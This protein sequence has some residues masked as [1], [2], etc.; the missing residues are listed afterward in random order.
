MI[1]HVCIGVRTGNAGRSDVCAQHG[2][3]GGLRG[4]RSDTADRTQLPSD[5]RSCTLL[6]RSVVV[7]DK[8]W[9]GL[10]FR[11]LGA[12]FDYL[13]TLLETTKRLCKG[14][15]VAGMSLL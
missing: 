12:W 14:N 6:K 15:L 13:S 4:A 5:R 3:K 7:V 10:P 2:T 8:S 9:D 1:Y 11:V